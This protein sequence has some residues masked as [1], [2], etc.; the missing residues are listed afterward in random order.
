MTDPYISPSAG[1]EPSA[2]TVGPPAERMTAGLSPYG[3]QPP[4]PQSRYDQGPRRTPWHQRPASKEMAGW[5][6]GLSFVPCLITMVIAAVFAIIVLNR[7]NGGRNYGRGF[8]IAA[9]CVVGLW[10]VVGIGAV[11]VGIAT[12]AGPENERATLAPTELRVGHCFDLGPDGEVTSVAV[13]P[14]DEPHQT[15]VFSEFELPNEKEFPGYEAVI[16]DAEAGCARRFP[17]FVGIPVKDSELEIHIIYPHE[18]AWPGSRTVTCT[19]SQ[20]ADRP[21]Q[22]TLRGSKR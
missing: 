12:D 15:E 7:D 3:A 18:S 4:G 13:V 16:A 17:E 11:A 20:P 2:P 5:A 8:A 14:C 19:I 21:H 9:L 6:L 1:Q 10:V 22:G